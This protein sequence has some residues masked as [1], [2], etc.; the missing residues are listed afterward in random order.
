MKIGLFAHGGS[1]NHGCEAL[2][3]SSMRFLGEHE[4]TIL[5]ERPEDDL[6]Y[7]LDELAH[8][9]PS[10]SDMPKGIGYLAYALNM[11]LGRKIGRAHV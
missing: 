1:G 4:Y 11:K 5:S 6:R 8:I 3:R 10:Q 9:V 7:G 2:A